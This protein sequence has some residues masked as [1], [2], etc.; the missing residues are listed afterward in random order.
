MRAPSPTTATKVFDLPKIFWAA[1]MPMAAE[2]AVLEWPV[3]KTSEGCSSRL[4]NPE[5]PLK[6]RMWCRSSFLPVR[7]LCGYD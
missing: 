1:A 6:L 2:M 3:P 5:M 7:T 4:G